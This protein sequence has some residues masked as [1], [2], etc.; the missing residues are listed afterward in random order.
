MRCLVIDDDKFERDGLRYMI[1][2]LGIEIEVSDVRNGKLGLELM[3]REHF[4]IVIT[5]IKM[6]V[7]DGIA[8]LERAKLRWPDRVYII[9]SGHSD[10]DF[11]KKAISLQ[12]MEFLVKP[13]V[14]AEFDKV[15]KN[16]IRHI[17]KTKRQISSE[18]LK[19]LRDDSLFFDISGINGY[20]YLLWGGEI[21]EENRIE[22]EK[23]CVLLPL[24]N[25]RYLA[26]RD[27]SRERKE[28]PWSSCGV[29]GGI[30]SEVRKDWESVRQAYHRIIEEKEACIL[31]RGFIAEE[32][33]CRTP[34]SCRIEAGEGAEE[35]LL[36][37]IR[38]QDCLRKES[39]VK[40]MDSISDRELPFALKWQ[41]AEFLEDLEQMIL[42]G[43]AQDGVIY[44]VKAYISKHYHEE[45]SVETLAKAVY[46]TPSYLC[47]I[48]KKETGAT[49]VGY[50]P[51]Y[52]I[53]RA[54]ELL[55]EGKLKT[56]QIAKQVGYNNI[57][58]F[59]SVFKAKAGTTPGN[60]RKEQG[61]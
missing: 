31:R 58:Y 50:L 12:V 28:L 2:R 34:V 32:R 47:T 51:Q 24:G 17:E 55:R 20:I 43:K 36:E 4:D 3:E 56:A 8:F 13:V 21:A 46:L 60:Y 15:M 40:L 16:A 39:L 14:D 38:G 7:M 42:E 11:A 35:E 53:E 61:D 29:M 5:D 30:R 37:F 18:M 22:L 49:L 33:L 48:F 44:Q 25:G 6:P 59:N 1:D 52:R 19:H 9:Y 57:S 26:Y 54:M 10:F 41:N 45:L 27:K 23:E